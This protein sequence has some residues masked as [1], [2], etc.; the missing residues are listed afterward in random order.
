MYRNTNGTSIIKSY[1]HLPNCCLPQTKMSHEKE[2]TVINDV[3]GKTKG[4]NITKTL[5]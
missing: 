5:A 3:S 1:L 2:F 4:G